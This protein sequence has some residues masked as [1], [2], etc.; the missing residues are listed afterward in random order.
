MSWFILSIVFLLITIWMLKG[1]T[2][3]SYQGKYE[4]NSFYMP[5]WGLFILY[6]LYLIPYCGVIFFIV[7]V[8]WFYIWSFAKPHGSY[9]EYILITL[10]EKNKIHK[11]LRAIH[12]FL[13]KPIK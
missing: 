1:T 13:N 10:S 2:F 8:I 11:L 6:L 7:W 3:T 9:N 12:N 4:D 5:I